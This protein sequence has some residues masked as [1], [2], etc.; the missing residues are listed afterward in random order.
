MSK[1]FYIID[2]RAMTEAIAQL[3]KPL[4]KQQQ[5]ILSAMVQMDRPATGSEIIAHAV[6]HQGLVTRQKYDV[7]YAWYARSN[8]KLGVSL[9]TN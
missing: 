5:L 8:E 9:K 4:P 1:K 2:A 6:E 7:L 3:E